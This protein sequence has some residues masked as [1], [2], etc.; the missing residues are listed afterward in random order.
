MREEYEDLGYDDWQEIL[1]DE[2]DEEEE[3]D[4]PRPLFVLP[5]LVTAIGYISFDV[6][7]RTTDLSL[8]TLIMWALALGSIVGLWVAHDVVEWVKRRDDRLSIP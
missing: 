8:T 2:N 3:G 7:R 6:L 4:T 5:L 1:I